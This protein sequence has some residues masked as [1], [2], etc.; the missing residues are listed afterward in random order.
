MALEGFRMVGMD[1]KTPLAIRER[2]FC[3]EVPWPLGMVREMVVLSTCQRHEVY[4]VGEKEDTEAVQKALFPGFPQEA[5]LCLSGGDVVRRLFRVTCGLESLALGEH[6][7]L[8][9]VKRAWEKAREEKRCGKDLNRLFLRAITLGKKVRAKTFL[10]SASFSIPSLVVQL[11]ERFLGD[12]QGKRV[13]LIGTGEMGRLL[14]TYFLERG[15]GEIRVSSRN[16]KRALSLQREFPTIKLLPYWEK[17]EYLRGCDL[18]VSATEAPHYTL[19]FQPFRRV[20]PEVP[21]L[22]FDLGLPRN[23]DP[24]IAT[25]EGVRLSTLE[26]LEGIARERRSRLVQ[27]VAKVEAMIEEAVRLFCRSLEWDELFRT[28]TTNFQEIALEELSQLFRNIPYLGREDQDRVIETVFRANRRFLICIRTVLQSEDKGVNRDSE[29]PK[30][31]S[32]W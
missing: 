4:F 21:R 29:R 28:L 6:Q 8:G 7:I 5:L 3:R 32:S 24:K 2:Y 20:W 31:Y 15:V 14:I 16:P 23:I 17:Y 18:L 12:L 19:E 11:A 27:D 10:G 25:L 9:Q 1:E 26:D 22:L 13:F 30:G